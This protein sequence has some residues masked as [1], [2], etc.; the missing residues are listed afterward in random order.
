ENDLMRFRTEHTR[1]AIAGIIDRRA[2]LAP[3]RVNARWISKMPLE[4]RTHLRE[5]FG[6]ERSRCVVVEVDHRGKNGRHL[7]SYLGR[8]QATEQSRY[9][10]PRSL[11][12]LNFRLSP[13]RT[14]IARSGPLLD[15]TNRLYCKPG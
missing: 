6:R 2:R 14:F 15:F 10:F 5:R 7:Y 12:L 13:L 11:A 3:R 8:A 1:H 9:I 4:V